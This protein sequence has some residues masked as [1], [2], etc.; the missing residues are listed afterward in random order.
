MNS[1]LES[2]PLLY[3]LFI[4]TLVH[5]GYFLL[6]KDV[7]S[8]FLF[9]LVSI[10]VYLVIP[11]MIIVL[12]VTLLFV[13][14]LYIVNK[15]YPSQEGFRG[16]VTIKDAS[17]ADIPADEFI[18]N[19]FKTMHPNIK[20]TKGPKKEKQ[21]NQ[22]EEVDEEVGNTLEEVDTQSKKMNTMIDKIKSVSPEMVDSLK[23]L[24]S[25][26]IVELN[27]LINNMNKIATTLKE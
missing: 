8:V 21:E 3:F 26:D 1:F 15:S 22:V 9:C 13:D 6:L 16:T 11:N 23:M 7:R 5:L 4:T 10:F 17:G 20:K 2:V 14:L 27:K 18:E 12:G 25:I 19:A 24:H